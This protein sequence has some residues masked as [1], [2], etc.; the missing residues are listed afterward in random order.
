VERFAYLVTEREALCSIA[1]SLKRI[2]DAQE[3]Q[4]DRMDALDNPPSLEQQ[5]AA[6]RSLMPAR[7]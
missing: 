3:R 6:V 4:A 1:V 5:L 7:T 2:A